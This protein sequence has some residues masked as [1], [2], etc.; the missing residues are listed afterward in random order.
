M[1][2]CLIVLILPSHSIG[3]TASRHARFRK[4][5][6][7]QQLPPTLSAD[8][9]SLVFMLPCFSPA[10]QGQAL[11]ALLL[12]FSALNSPSSAIDLLVMTPA[13]LPFVSIHALFRPWR[14]PCVPYPIKGPIVTSGKINVLHLISA[15]A[16]IVSLTIDPRCL[17]YEAN[18]ETADN[19]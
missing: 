19:L 11:L 4:A 3:L 7:L 5:W 13:I 1:S 12:P 14:S 18:A 17:R 6:N 8:I 16:E 15:W 9:S 10:I 2:S